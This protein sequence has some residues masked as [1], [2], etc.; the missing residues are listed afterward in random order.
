MSVVQFLSFSFNQIP[1][2]GGYKLIFSPYTIFHFNFQYV[3][4][5]KYIICISVCNPNNE[6]VLE[7][8]LCKNKMAD[9]KRQ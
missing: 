8:I 5:D 9:F 1:F 2:L 3:T 7:F 4:L 6:F